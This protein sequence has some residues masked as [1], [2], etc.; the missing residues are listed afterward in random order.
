MSVLLI[1]SGLLV[2]TVAIGR[3]VAALI[4]G[5]PNER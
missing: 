2:L 5:K 1:I 4:M 3:P